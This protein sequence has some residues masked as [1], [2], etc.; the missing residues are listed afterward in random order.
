MVPDERMSVMKLTVKGKN[1]TITDA[2][3]NYV[4]KR[5]DKL[6]KYFQDEMHGTVTL[7]IEKNAQIAEATFPIN[8]YILRAEESSDDM[9]ASIDGIVE[10]IER[11]IRKYKTR[12]NRKARQ[13]NQAMLAFKPFEDDVEPSDDSM[14]LSDGI[15]I[16]KVKHFN[17]KPMDPEEAVMQMELLDHDF[18]V[19]LNDESQAIDVVY[20]RKDGKYGLIQPETN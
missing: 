10:K 3:E 14:Q 16:T 13:Q 20:R 9:Y 17:V 5:F 11:Q 15:E 4:E 6:E 12:V 2:L 7:S 8:H 18:F 1:I 19:F